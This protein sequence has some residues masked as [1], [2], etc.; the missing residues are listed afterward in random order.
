[1]VQLSLLDHRRHNTFQLNT[2]RWHKC[3]QIRKE[4]KISNEQ[5]VRKRCS[6]I[7]DE[8]DSFYFYFLLPELRPQDVGIQ[9]KGSRKWKW[10]E[11]WQWDTANTSQQVTFTSSGVPLLAIPLKVRSQKMKHGQYVGNHFHTFISFEPNRHIF[12]ITYSIAT[13]PVQQHKLNMRY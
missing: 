2:A 13:Y 7:L 9:V 6:E 8:T 3:I 12:H 4:K 5:W 1:M 11:A 10:K